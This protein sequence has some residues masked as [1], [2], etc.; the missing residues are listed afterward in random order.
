[1][2]S[3]N[4]IGGRLRPD[5]A[6]DGLIALQAAGGEILHGDAHGRTPGPEPVMSVRTVHLR[7]SAQ[8][9]A[10]K[11]NVWPVTV[12]RA[13][14]LGDLTQVHV[15]WGG[16]ELV[17]RQTAAMPPAEGMIVYL[18]IDPAHCVL[19]EPGEALQVEPAQQ[20][21]VRPVLANLPTE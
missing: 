4:L 18:S 12:R 17:I 1:V 5:L 7:I 20:Q 3:A 21:E 14:F 11:V 8:A 6:A 2:G 15:D 16:R 19:L 9:P 10:S 13:I